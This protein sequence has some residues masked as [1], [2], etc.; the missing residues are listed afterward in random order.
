[1]KHESANLDLLRSIAVGLVVA[2]HLPQ[3]GGRTDPP[4]SVPA[5][6]HVGV[7][8]FFV[9]TTLVLLQ[10]L[11]RTGGMAA[12]FFVRRFFRIYPL[13]VFAVLLTA[14]LYAING[15]SLSLAMLAS[16]VL[17]VQNITDHRSIVT[18]MWS[19]PFEVQMYLVLPALYAITKTRHAAIK[20]CALWLAGVCLAFIPLLQFVPCFL[21]GALAYTMRERRRIISPAALFA[22]VGVMAAALPVLSAYGAPEVQMLWMACPVIGVLLAHAREID[23]EGITARGAHVVAKYSYGIY[24]TH[25]LAIVS[26][27][28]SENSGVVNWIWLLMSIPS[29]ALVTYHFIERPGIELGRRLALLLEARLES[30]AGRLGITERR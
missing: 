24:L 18:P 17:L 2:S 26:A 22:V 16:N 5:M 15:N 13:S 1:M 28:P 19:L 4:F 29:L 11:D 23:H 27:F 12:P 30:P 6:G 7:A 9:H 20:V 10:S 8:L 14:A 21:G 25:M 3:F